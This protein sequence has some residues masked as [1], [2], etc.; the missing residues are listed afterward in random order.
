MEVSLNRNADASL[1]Q[2]AYEEGEITLLTFLMENSYYLSA[3]TR[4]LETRRD[5]ELILCSLLAWQL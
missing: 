5:L 4:L 3:R 1:L 2:R